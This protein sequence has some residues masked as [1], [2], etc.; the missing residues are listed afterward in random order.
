MFQY[1]VRK[2]I[3][4]IPVLLGVT[5]AVFLILQ[6]TPG[7]PA[8]LLAGPEAYEE[9]IEAIRERL[10][11]NDPMYVQYGRFVYNAARLDFGT[12]FRTNRP[13]RD[14]IMSRFPHTIELA[15][16][17]MFWATIVGVAI[18]IFAGVRPNSAGDGMSMG[19]ALLGV[20][21]PSFWIGL[22]LMLLFSY[23]LGW[24]PASGRDGPIWTMAGLQ[25]MLMPALTLG[26]SPAAVL[27]RMTR[28]SMLEVM[29][30]DYIRTARSKG[31]AERVVVYRHAL[32]NALIPVITLVGLQLGALLG[33][34]LITEQVFAWP[35]IGTLIING[36]NARDYPMVQACIMLVATIFV[37]INLLVDMTYSFIDPR[38]KYS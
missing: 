11:L 33:G 38:I 4:S 19:A 5:L 22:L 20:S 8:R 9:D 32:R 2:L 7:D 30:H 13:V 10:G 21:A 23:K 16:A 34:A 29:G 28:S 17:S 37:G 31:L 27:A 25:T 14:D 6:L 35:G 18:G 15:L 24:L 26:A 3:T 36:I 1:A 12:S